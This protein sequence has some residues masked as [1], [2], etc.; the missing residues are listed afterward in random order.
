M[1]Q[2]LFTICTTLSI[3]L[4]LQ[5]SSQ[6]NK[7]KQDLN[8]NSEETLTQNVPAETIIPGETIKKPKRKHFIKAVIRY[9]NGYQLRKSANNADTLSTHLYFGRP[10]YISDTII[11][12]TID[13]VA[14]YWYEVIING[15]STPPGKA[16][17]FSDVVYYDSSMTYEVLRNRL[18]IKD[19]PNLD[20][21]GDEQELKV[22]LK[23][24]EYIT[25]DKGMD[26]E[27]YFSQFVKPLNSYLFH[28]VCYGEN[29]Y[30]F[31][32]NFETGKKTTF[33]NLP[34]FNNSYTYFFVREYSVYEG[35]VNAISIYKLTDNQTEKVFS[36]GLLS[37][38]RQAKWLNDYKI[39]IPYESSSYRTGNTK[40]S[41]IST[42]TK[43]NNEW[44]IYPKNEMLAETLLMFE[45]FE[46]KNKEFKESKYSREQGYFDFELND[47]TIDLEDS[48]GYTNTVPALKIISTD[49]AIDKIKIE[50]LFK[51]VL[52][53]EK[54]G[55]FSIDDYYS[56]Y[57]ELLKAYVRIYL[58]LMDNFGKEK[59]MLIYSHALENEDKDYPRR[60][61]REFMVEYNIDLKANVMHKTGNG[62]IIGF[63]M[64][65]LYDGSSEVC[66]QVAI[67]LLKKYDSSFYN[68]YVVGDGIKKEALQSFPNAIYTN[69]KDKSRQD[70]SISDRQI[71][72]HWIEYQI[73]LNG[74][75]KWV[76]AENISF[77]K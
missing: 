64:R 34:Q 55:Y 43:E 36:T 54:L 7:Q 60:F 16:Y 37:G 32:V 1:K 12:D 29:E 31:F 76:S 51:I 30:S 48:S 77:P 58:A 2:V 18:L 62:S 50:K 8:A 61:Y 5:C 17:V 69:F 15:P 35:E 68:K 22:K 19:Y 3:F 74:T 45:E 13:G 70:E 46:V 14:G 28:S 72:D 6:H 11:P 59:L 71:K 25:I 53:L 38:H 67:D 73:V 24:G 57:S 21:I 41:F 42:I 75:L 56:T 20:I 27:T 39:T 66:Y 33:T 47:I 49:S 9:K 52:S 4:L 65:R 40:Q 10:V 44:D 26:C 63:W 23:S